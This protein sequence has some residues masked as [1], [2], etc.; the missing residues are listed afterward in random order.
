M[1]NMWRHSQHLKD[2]FQKYIIH[3]GDSNIELLRKLVYHI[4]RSNRNY[5]GGQI[6]TRVESELLQFLPELFEFFADD[7]ENCDKRQYTIECQTT[8]HINL[9]TYLDWIAYP[10]SYG[11]I[12]EKLFNQ[13][14]SPPETHEYDIGTINHPREIIGDIRTKAQEYIKK[15]F[16]RRSIN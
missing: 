11:N 16:F 4:Y 3:G 9:N 13:M 7:I 1:T 12:Y 8:Q 15:R 5:L 2:N 14:I 6:E 10:Q